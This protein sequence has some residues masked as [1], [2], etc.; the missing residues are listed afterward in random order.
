MCIHA[1]LTY[2]S[3]R[4]VS[5]RVMSYTACCSHVQSRD[6]RSSRTSG[7]QNFAEKALKSVT[8]L[9]PFYQLTSTVL[10]INTGLRQK[11][12]HVRGILMRMR[13]CGCGE[14][15]SPEVSSIPTLSFQVRTSSASAQTVH[16][17]RLSCTAVT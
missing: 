9:L 5:H 15:G 16:Q 12:L 14:L 8:L 11:R 17:R 6:Q 1:Y 7:T 10:G 13:I 2:F 4:C 3:S